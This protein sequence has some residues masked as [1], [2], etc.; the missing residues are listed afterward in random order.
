VKNLPLG[1]PMP[2]TPPDLETQRPVWSADGTR[3][4][5]IAG[6]SLGNSHVR[7]VA[8]D[9]S[10]PAPDT[11]YYDEADD[12]WEVHATP[13]ADVIVVRRGTTAASAGEADIGIVDL[14]TGSFVPFAAT[15]A[16]E[17]AMALSPDGRWL[18]YVTD[19]SG[20]Q[21]VVVQPF[22][23]GGARTQVSS[24]G[25]AEPVWSGSGDRLFYR[26]PDL[27]MMAVDVT[28]TPS[29]RVTSPAR[30][31]RTAQFRAAGTHRRYQVAEDGRFLMLT[32]PNLGVSTQGDLILVKNWF[33]AVRERIG[34]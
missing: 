2:L 4:L 23:G 9:G 25:G 6:D 10:S 28:T 31:F 26:D 3:I 24:A 7:S 18:A 11:V 1:P 12:V 5:Y 22:P 32:N 21:E 20:Q 14:R 8:A 34:R 29:F 13:D 33:T 19:E 17:N 27:F 30:L 16:N 15:G